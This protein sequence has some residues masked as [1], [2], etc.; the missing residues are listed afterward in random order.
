[1]ASP[2]ASRVVPT[3]S[4]AV[5]VAVAAAAAVA[6]DLICPILAVLLLFFNTEDD[7]DVDDDNS[8]TS[9][10]AF[11]ASRALALGMTAAAFFT[12]ECFSTLV[13][14]AMGVC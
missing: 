3:I 4:V 5:A 13:F 8:G 11:K 9:K 10:A 14:D 2:V 1:V 6:I 7:E 12:T